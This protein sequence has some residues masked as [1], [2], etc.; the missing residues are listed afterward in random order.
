M[1]N[2]PSFAPTLPGSWRYRDVAAT[3]MTLVGLLM[4]GIGVGSG[5]VTMPFLAFG[6]VPFAL[7]LAH[8]WHA[9]RSDHSAVSRSATTSRRAAETNDYGGDEAV[10]LLKERYAA[11]ELDEDE[12]DQRLERLVALEEIEDGDDSEPKTVVRERT[13]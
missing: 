7:G 6:V 2:L 8:L 9:T 1:S 13:N 3:V 5:Y 10:A 4:L 11:G 12:L